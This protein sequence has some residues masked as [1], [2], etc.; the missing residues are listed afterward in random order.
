MIFVTGATGN[1]GREVVN[2]LLDGGVLTLVGT[3]AARFIRLQ[4]SAAVSTSAI[5]D[6]AR[7]AQ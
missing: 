1:A 5:G 3:I 4:K 2:L 6:T 7:Q